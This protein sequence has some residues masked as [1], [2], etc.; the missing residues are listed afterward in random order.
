MYPVSPKLYFG[1]LSNLVKLIEE[2]KSHHRKR[3]A[4]SVFL[5]LDKNDD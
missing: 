1:S 2:A 4:Y 3:E 5:A